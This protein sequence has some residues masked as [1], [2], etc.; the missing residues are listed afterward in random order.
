MK[1][2][3]FILFA[4][5]ILLAILAN[6]FVIAKYILIGISAIAVIG[7]LVGG[8]IGLVNMFRK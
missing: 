7:A 5:F 8:I 2:A 1:I 4:S 3:L 6:W